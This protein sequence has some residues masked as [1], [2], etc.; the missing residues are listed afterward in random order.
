MRGTARG[1]TSPA[2]TGA[3]YLPRVSAP[4][5]DIAHLTADFIGASALH[6]AD[7]SLVS[8]ILVA[9][10]GAAGMKAS[11]APVVITH[12]GGG[13][14]V[15]L[16]LDGCHMSIHTMPERELAILD[17]IAIAPH[18]PQRALDVVSRRL[19]ARTVR[20]ERRHRGG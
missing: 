5:R 7:Q 19:A 13:L 17:V 20:A 6:L 11:G 16:P 4:P 9:A 1:T 2:A 18:D 3:P 8:G 14:S 10:A 15:I 12:P